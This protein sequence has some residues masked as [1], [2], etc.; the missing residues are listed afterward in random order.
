M[1]FR[2][3]KGI[4]S[5]ALQ[6]KDDRIIEAAK[7]R[8]FAEAFFILLSIGENRLKYRKQYKE[9][10][11]ELNKYKFNIATNKEAPKKFRLLAMLSII[12]INLA[13]F[14]SKLK[15]RKKV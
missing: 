1:L 7:F 10:C 12:N 5:H 13:M 15:I 2:S 3:T 11:G 4:V 14:L 8:H 9:A 6:K